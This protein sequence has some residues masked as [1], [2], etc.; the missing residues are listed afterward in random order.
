MI[1]TQS[2]KAT[3]LTINFIHD[4]Y[5][6][7][8]EQDHQEGVDVQKR[9]EVYKNTMY[10]NNTSRWR[11]EW[12]VISYQRYK[13]NNDLSEG[14]VISYQRYEYND[15]LSEGLS[16][17]NNTTN[18][19]EGLPVVNDTTSLSERLPVIN[20]TINLSKWLLV[21]ND[22]TNLSEGLPVINDT[23]AKMTCVVVLS[24]NVWWPVWSLACVAYD[25][26]GRWPVWPM[27]CDLCGQWPVWSITCLG[28][29]LSRSR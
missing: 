23:S 19:S 28:Q 1:K 24:I 29:R 27:T 17:I 16:V 25:L 11:P 22:T 6:S 4:V 2:L 18:L 20:D 3:L 12:R 5:M 14:L 9:Y 15:D 21:I 7:L 8:L 10:E 26:W 13:Y